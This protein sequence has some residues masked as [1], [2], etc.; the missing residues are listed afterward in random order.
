M[1]TRWGAAKVD[2]SGVE[3]VVEGTPNARRL[4]EKCGFR[5]TIEEMRLDVSDEFADRRKP[6]LVFLQRQVGV[7]GRP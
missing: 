4:Y 5:T 7:Q 3:A 6:E 1:L 2:E